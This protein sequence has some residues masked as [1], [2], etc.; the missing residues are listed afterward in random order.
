VN[1]DGTVNAANS[2]GVATANV[3]HATPG[4]YCISGLGFAPRNA[5]ASAGETGDAFSIITQIGVALGCGP[6]TQ[7]SVATDVG[8]DNE[9]MINI[10]N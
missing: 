4:L 7:I 6:G 9:F 5:V 8:T 3:I 10:N 1:A 2:K